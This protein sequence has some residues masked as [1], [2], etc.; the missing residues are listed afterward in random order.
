MNTFWIG[1]KQYQTKRTLHLRDR[2][3]LPACGAGRT[4]RYDRPLTAP[5]FPDVTCKKCLSL[6][7]EDKA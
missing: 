2:N 7:E 5:E 3:G 6:F 1:K 4:P